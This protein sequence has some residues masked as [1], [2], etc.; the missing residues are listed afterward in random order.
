MGPPVP[1]DDSIISW[2]THQDRNWSELNTWAFT[3]V[4]TPVFSSVQLLTL[5]L[6][7]WP[8]RLYCHL[9]GLGTSFNSNFPSP[10]P[11]PVAWQYWQNMITCY[12]LVIHWLGLILIL[13][14]LFLFAVLPVLPHLAALLPV[15]LNHVRLLAAA[16]HVLLHLVLTHHYCLPC[17]HEV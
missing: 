11:V 16:V 10:I 5:F 6:G 15:L 7:G 9:L 17:N 8:M 1:W 4:N 13:V 2:D 3:I 12:W 14:V